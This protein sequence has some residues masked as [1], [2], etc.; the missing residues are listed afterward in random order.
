MLPLTSRAWV[1]PSSDDEVGELERELRVVEYLRVMRYT[2]VVQDLADLLLTLPDLRG[3]RCT[4][5]CPAHAPR[6]PCHHVRPRGLLTCL[7][8]LLACGAVRV[9]V[10][11]CSICCSRVT[12][13]MTT[14]LCTFHHDQV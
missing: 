4:P 10:L 2:F 8:T 3:A 11:Q 9:S 13:H 1:Q 7:H 6:V 12:A 5:P 14:D